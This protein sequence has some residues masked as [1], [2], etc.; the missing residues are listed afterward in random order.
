MGVVGFGRIGKS[1]AVRAVGFGMNVV[2]YDP[3]LTFAS[4]GV[5]EVDFD[6]LLA[7]SDVVSLH[8]PLTEATHGLFN[9]DVFSR[10]KPDAIL[11]NTARGQLVH[12][13]DLVDALRSGQ[14]A[15]AGLDVFDREPPPSDH[16]LWG[17]PNV[18]LSPH[19]AGIDTLAMEEMATMAAWCIVELAEGRW[20]SQCVVNP[21]VADGW[22]W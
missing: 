18:I 22:L 14:L 15:G 16:P 13:L 19:M 3:S 21:E 8:L 4:N 12:E 6:E 17:L 2:A 11:I 1:V 5:R 10:M 7:E 9:R 20:P